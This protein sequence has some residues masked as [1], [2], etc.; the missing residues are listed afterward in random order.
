MTGPQLRRFSEGARRTVLPV[1]GWRTDWCL[2]LAT[3]RAYVLRWAANPIMLL[4]SPLGPILGLVGFTVV[5]HVAGQSRAGGQDIVGFLVIGMLATQAWTAAVWGSGNALQA[6]IYSGTVGALVVAP[7]RTSAV[8]LGYGIGSAVWGLP[9]L[10]ACIGVGL[11]LGAHFDIQ[12]PVAAVVSLVAVYGS[13]LAVGLGF[14]GLFILSRQS[15]ALSNFLQAPIYLL[16]GFYVPRSALPSWLQWISEVI[17][18]AHAVD[19]LRLTALSGGS[20]STVWRS[21]LAT[22]ATAAVFLVAGGWSLA[23]MDDAIRRRATLDLL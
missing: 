21:L 19:A 11:G 4:R 5:Y 10:V 7:G 9:G 13:A 20:F 12:H 16:A 17:P 22:V 3:V 2:M 15:N 23:R 14:G 8:M 18:I 6:E 1:R